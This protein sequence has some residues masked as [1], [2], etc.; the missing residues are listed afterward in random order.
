MALFYSP[1]GCYESEKSSG[2]ARWLSGERDLLLSLVEG[3][4][5]LLVSPDLYLSLYTHTHI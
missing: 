3:G 1:Y 2:T 5:Q 4:N